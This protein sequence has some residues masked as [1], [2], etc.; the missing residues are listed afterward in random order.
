MLLSSHADAVGALNLLRDRRGQTESQF[1]PSASCPH[2][3]SSRNLIRKWAKLIRQPFSSDIWSETLIPR[4]IC[5]GGRGK[6]HILDPHFQRSIVLA[7]AECST[8]RSE[9]HR[10]TESH[11]LEGTHMITESNTWL[12]R[13]QPQKSHHVSSLV[14]T[15]PTGEKEW[16]GIPLT[17]IWQWPAHHWTKSDVFPGSAGPRLAALDCPGQRW[18]LGCWTPHLAAHWLNGKR[19]E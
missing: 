8:N 7:A 11:E 16:V 3:V 13:G 5:E 10:I 14:S 17:W 18:S 6:C 4:I 15:A 1:C 9:P 2:G 19:K 12:C